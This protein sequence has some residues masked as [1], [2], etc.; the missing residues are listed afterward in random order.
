VDFDPFVRGA[1]PVGVCSGYLTDPG[2]DDRPLPYE[3]WYPAS[4]RS[5]GLDLSPLTQDSFSVLPDSPA[6]R[7]AAV[8][9]A[10]VEPGLYPL[11]LYSHTSLG[12]RRQS[13]FVCTHLASH[14]YV[15]AAAD[16]TGN[17]FADYVERARAGATLKA[18]EREDMLRRI[19]ADRV[20]D[21][22]FVTDW[23]LSQSDLAAH[24]DRAR[25]GLVGW[26]FGGWA[27]LAAPEVDDRFGAIVALAPGGTS[28]PL[29]GIIPATLSYV[30]QRDVPT[31]YL[32]AECDRYTLLDGIVELYDRTPSSKYL[33]AL[34]YA[35]HDHF[36]DHIEVELCP[37]QHAHLF[38]RGLALAHFEAFLGSNVSARAFLAADPAA[39]LR[40]R[41]VDVLPIHEISLR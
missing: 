11:V 4:G 12:H 34:R 32:A 7:Q 1:Y 13:T 9:D 20:P 8:R 2:R 40:A 31:L 41:G 28:R 39:V 5:F 23:L 21:V 29:P 26:S 16:H 17:S 35:D 10:A 27:V 22:R 24:I 25:I 30:W 14:G 6:L 3:V 33:F 18:H 15:V 19:I 36:G 37:K 38:T